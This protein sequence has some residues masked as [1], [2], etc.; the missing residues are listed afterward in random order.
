MIY[1]ITTYN[2]CFGVVSE[3]GMIIDSAPIG[4]KAIGMSDE[5][6]MKYFRNRWKAKIERIRK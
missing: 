1:R 5:E 2:A 6:M 3:S 4:R